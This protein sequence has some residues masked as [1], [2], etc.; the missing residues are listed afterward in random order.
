V[1]EQPKKKLSDYGMDDESEI[2]QAIIS[3][4]EQGLIK[5]SGRRRDGLIVWVPV[6]QARH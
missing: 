2:A 4:L 6:E 1:T 3:L 5:D